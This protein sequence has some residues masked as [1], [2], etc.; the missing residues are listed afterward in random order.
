MRN[1][2]H[3]SIFYIQIL[4]VSWLKERRV[5]MMCK[6]CIVLIFRRVHRIHFMQ[7]RKTELLQARAAVGLFENIFLL[8]CP[9]AHT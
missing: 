8:M 6:M 1:V 3:L 2:L 7:A 9:R 4:H 5:H